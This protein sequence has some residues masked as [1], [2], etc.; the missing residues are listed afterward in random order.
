LTGYPGRDGVP[1]GYT[2]DKTGLALFNL[3]EDVGER[4][5]VAGQNPEVVARLLRYADAA[6]DDLG[7]SLTKQIGKNVR[8]PGRVE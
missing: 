1:D 2:Q 5:D 7:D 8:E 4:F 6:R 3:R